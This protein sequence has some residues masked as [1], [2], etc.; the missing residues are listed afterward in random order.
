MRT[1]SLQFK[2]ILLAAC[3]M[4][5]ALAASIFSLS[6]VYGSI[7]EL[8]RITREDFQSQQAILRAS[9]SLRQQVQEWKNILLRGAEPSLLEKYWG[10][11]EREEKETASLV[12]EARAGIRQPEVLAKLEE[13]MTAHRAA[14]EAYRKA[15]QEFKQKGHEPKVADAAV[16]GA[17]RIAAKLL[18]DAEKAAQD[19]GAQATMAAVKTAESGYVL[20][21]AGTV[22]AMVAALIA[23]AL[24]VRRSVLGPIGAAVGYAERIAQGDLTARIEARSRDEAGQLIAALARMNAGLS[25]VVSQVRASSESV[26]AASGQVSMG[27]A[28]LAQRTEEQARASRRPPPAWRSSRARCARTRTTRSAPTASR[29]TPRSAPS[30]AAPSGPRGHR[31]WTASASAGKIAEIISVIDAIAFQTNIL[32]LNAAVEA[33]RAGEQGR[34]FAVVAAEVR[35]L[36]QRSAQAAKEIKELIGAS[37]SQAKEGTE[38]VEKAGDTIQALVIDVKQVSELMGSIAEASAEQ[39]RGVQQVNK[40][41]D[42]DGQG[43]AAERG[44]GAAVGFRGRGHASPGRRAGAGG[45]RVPAGRC[46]Q[47]ARGPAPRRRPAA[48]AGIDAPEGIAHADSR[49]ARGGGGRRGMAL[50]ATTM[51]G[52]LT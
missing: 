52:V 24:F 42:R 44:G 1:S 22:V 41:R 26:V 8:D 45:E 40:T 14:G 48:R 36:A 50:A 51:G 12:R 6:R 4:A 46:G 3:A 47:Q 11:F 39:S 21:I 33:A 25:D 7:T 10:Q 43:R 20:A 23:L 27:T 16:A 49:Q 37:V 2:V 32:A 18:S 5:F 35:S 30:R 34:G 15:L 17:D 19:H 13:F 29:A 31:P 9:I 28:D 38:L